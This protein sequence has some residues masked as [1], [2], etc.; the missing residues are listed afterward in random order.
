MEV[1]HVPSRFLVATLEGPEIVV[2][3][4]DDLLVQRQVAGPAQQIYCGRLD[5]TQ[6]HERG[7]PADCNSKTCLGSV[8]NSNEMHAPARPPAD[9]L[10][11]FGLP[12][13]RNIGC[14]PAFRCATV[15]K[16]ARRDD[17]EWA[18]QRRNHATPS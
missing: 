13:D 18:V 14:G 12:F 16:Q 6:A 8:R 10:D 9:C 5:D 3:N 2:T 1:D 11:N 4:R 7:D 15:A 17:A